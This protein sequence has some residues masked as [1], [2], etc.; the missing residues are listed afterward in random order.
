[1]CE[2]CGPRSRGDGG[3]PS[4]DTMRNWTSWT[5]K[6]WGMPARLVTS[7]ISVVS[8]ATIVPMWAVSMLCR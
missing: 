8:T 5:W 1:M 7:K 3:E 6:L 2:V 4:I